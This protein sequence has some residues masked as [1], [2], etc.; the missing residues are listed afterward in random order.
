MRPSDNRPSGAA[1]QT[2]DVSLFVERDKAALH[3]RVSDLLIFRHCCLRAA[4]G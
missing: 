3:Q 2:E 1:R 4:V